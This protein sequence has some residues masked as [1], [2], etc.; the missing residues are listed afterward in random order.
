[1][2]DD[3]STLQPVGFRFPA[4]VAP[5]LEEYADLQTSIG[6]TEHVQLFR[7]AAIDARNGEPLIVHCSDV[8][9]MKRI[10]ATFVLLLGVAPT[11]EQVSGR[12]SRGQ[13]PG[14]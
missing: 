7:Q 1:M 6:Q 9:E 3:L 11:I 8:D 2:T 4:K 13:T 12:E 14:G 5:K 10:A